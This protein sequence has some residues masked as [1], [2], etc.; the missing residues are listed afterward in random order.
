MGSLRRESCE[1]LSS[2][3]VFDNP[4]RRNPIYRRNGR[5]EPKAQNEL[6]N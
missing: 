3:D 1:E 4:I 5:I 6:Q 2:V